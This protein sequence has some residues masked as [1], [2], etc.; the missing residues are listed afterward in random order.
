VPAY[1]ESYIFRIETDEPG[2]FWTGHG[3]ILLPPDTVLPEPVLAPGAG[4]LID[5]PD[6]EQLLNGSAQR[7]DIVVS[8][9]DDETLAYAQEEASQVPG[10]AVWIGRIPF[11]ENWQ[12][13]AVE[14]E[15]SGEA[16]GVSIT[17]QNSEPGRERTLTLKV[18]SGDTTRSRSPFAFFTDADQRRDYPDDAFFDRVANIN[19]GTSRRWGPSA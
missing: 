2:T 9:V 4:A 13:G 12:Q 15:W 6:L 10:A 14:W 19:S 7:M 16:R 17:G 5:I 8:G 11:D 3:D 18:A 1:R